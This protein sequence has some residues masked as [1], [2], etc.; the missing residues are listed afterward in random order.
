M[1]LSVGLFSNQIT[2]GAPDYHTPTIMGKW[3]QE[4]LD[5]VNHKI[6]LQ[7]SYCLVIEA[8]VFDQFTLYPSN[9]IFLLNTED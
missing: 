1:I 8:S 9:R 2:E 4:I 5:C 3:K 7:K 6:L